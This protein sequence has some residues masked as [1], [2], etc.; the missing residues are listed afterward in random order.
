M[1]LPILQVDQLEAGTLY[2]LWAVPG[3]DTW[4]LW[5]MNNI[6]DVGPHTLRREGGKVF[7]GQEEVEHN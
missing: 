7:G 6:G 2:W 1:S 4:T 5:D 3:I